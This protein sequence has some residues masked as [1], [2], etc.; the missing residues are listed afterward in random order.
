[1]PISHSQFSLGKAAH[2]GRWVRLFPSCGCPQPRDPAVVL[3]WFQQGLLCVPLAEGKEQ[4]DSVV[5]HLS[6]TQMPLLRKGYM[7]LGLTGLQGR[8]GNGSSYVPR[9]ERGDND[10]WRAASATCPQRAAKE[11]QMS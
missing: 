8:P 10:G 1:M 4:G 5:A 11:H 2:V 7:G 6:S 9:E 3:P